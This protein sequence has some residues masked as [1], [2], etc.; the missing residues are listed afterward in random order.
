MSNRVIAPDAAIDLQTHT[1]LSDGRWTPEALIDYFVE[2]D[3]ALAA[4]TDHDRVDTTERLQSLAEEKGFTLLVATEMTTRWR[5]ELVD[6]LCFGFDVGDTPLNRLAQDVLRR[7]SANSEKVYRHLVAEGHVP[8]HDGA[9]LQRLLDA[10]SSDQT[11]VLVA[12]T[13]AHTDDDFPLGK[14][15][16]QAGYRFETN[17]L[18]DVVT[19]AHESNAV[20]LLAHPGRGGEFMLFDVPLLDELRAEI[21]IDGLEAHYPRHSDEQVAAFVAYADAHEWLVSAGS[22]SHKPESPPIKYRADLCRRLLAHL[23]VQVSAG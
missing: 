1:H 6:V 13:Q 4:I 21:P 20:V 11:N 10:P 19:A 22:D 17:D 5:D 15:F 14:V 7:Q 2:N 8:T 18:A 12:I 9:E 3:F 23:G 16:G